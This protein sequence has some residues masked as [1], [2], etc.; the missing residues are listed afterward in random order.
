MNQGGVP[1]Q[2]PI[3]LC[4]CCVKGVW[5]GYLERD[6][7]PETQNWYSYQVVILL[8]AMLWQVQEAVGMGPRSAESTFNLGTYDRSVESPMWNIQFLVSW[9]NKEF[10]PTILELQGTSRFFAVIFTLAN[11][12]YLQ[13]DTYIHPLDSLR[14][15]LH[16]YSFHSRIERGDHFP[17]VGTCVIL[18][19]SE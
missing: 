1:T 3:S 8:A 7:D 14:I 17:C 16:G 13:I 12:R 2:T 5:N 9:A 6:W 15:P 10:M 18:L 19:I 11:S 4:E